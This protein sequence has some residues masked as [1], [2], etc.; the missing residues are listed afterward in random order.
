MAVAATA[1]SSNSGA[2]MAVAAPGTRA[3]AT[4]VPL[5]VARGAVIRAPEGM[6]EVC[7]ITE[8]CMRSFFLL[9]KRQ[10]Y[11]FYTLPYPLMS[12]DLSE[13]WDRTRFFRT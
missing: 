13:F 11:V 7:L 6:A 10:G 3:A 12:E 5:P 9:F 1:A 8:V 4:A 2:A